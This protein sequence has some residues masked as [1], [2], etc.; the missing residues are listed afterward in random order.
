MRSP[1]RRTS[2]PSQ[3]KSANFLFLQA[4]PLLSH[5]AAQSG[6]ALALISAHSRY[7]RFAQLEWP[8]QK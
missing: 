6:L 7:S 3:S 2:Q 5:I 8:T 1:L 4:D